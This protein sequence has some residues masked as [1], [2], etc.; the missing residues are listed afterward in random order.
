MKKSH[1]FIFLILGILLLVLF[2]LYNN[3]NLFTG[4]KSEVEEPKPI[5]DNNKY[6]YVK[7][8]DINTKAKISFPVLSN[9]SAEPLYVE[10]YAKKYSNEN[11]GKYYSIVV[12]KSDLTLE[13]Y[14]IEKSGSIIEEYE[15][16][17]KKIVPSDIECAN[18]CKR[19]QVMDGEKLLADYLEIFI[20]TASGEIT[21]ISYY[22]TNNKIADDIINNIVSHIKVSN[23]AV[24][25]V[26]TIEGNNLNIPL[27]LGNNKKITVSLDKNI[28]E[29]V[30]REENT[31]RRTTIRD[32]ETN[33]TFVIRGLTKLSNKT[34]LESV[35]ISEY[36]PDP[37]SNRKEVT[38]G[39]K[40]FYEYSLDGIVDYS[41]IVDS[42]SAIL[43]QDINENFDINK[44]ANIIVK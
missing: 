11:D 39:N 6:D 3:T 18:L 35:D 8:Y 26:G 16:N 14:S 29:E 5:N 32:K 36:S 15:G 19:Y 25:K 4:N 44:L 38:V 40:T 21:E 23:D 42:D 24:Y 20:K 13:E 30:E 22:E 27:D 9:L 34:M 10:D 37:G 41:Y 2:V 1:G 12:N 33:L 28:Y 31:V 17:Q 7:S 43:I